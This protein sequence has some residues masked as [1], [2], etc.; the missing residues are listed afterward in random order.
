V[1]TTTLIGGLGNQLFQ[2]AAGRS[3][4]I[5]LDTKLIIDKTELNKENI[6]TTKRFYELD[7]FNVK[8]VTVDDKFEKPL[9]K[10]LNKFTFL[11][12]KYKEKDKSFDHNFF[13]LKDGVILYGYWQNPKYF[14]SISRELVE[15]L[16]P[17]NELSDKYLS[18]EQLILKENAVAVHI[19][20]GD[21]VTKKSAAKYH[22]TLPMS[23][24]YSAFEYINSNIYMPHYYIFSD[25]P[26]WSLLNLNTGNSKVTFINSNNKANAWEDLMLMKR[27][28]HH[29]IANSSFSW[30]GAWLAEHGEDFEYNRRIVIAPKNW[31]KNSN[32]NQLNERYL[33]SWLVI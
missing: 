32:L 27:C 33:N 25:D 22:G 26:E 15:D 30:W 12:K 9:S 29:I 7:K 24:Y 1:I 31:N 6:K 11:N 16:L 21:Y 28:K 13:S 14:E 3:L 2:Y 4:A 18:I 20:R 17:V 5:F 19:R 8:E 23:Y 10:I